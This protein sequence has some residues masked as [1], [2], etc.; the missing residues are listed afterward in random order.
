MTQYKFVTKWRAFTANAC[1]GVLRLFDPL[2]GALHLWYQ[3]I[4]SDLFGPFGYRTWILV[5]TTTVG[6]YSGVYA[7]IVARHD[8]LINRAL[9][10]RN[11]FVTMVS[12][13]NRTSFVTAM[14]DFGP[15]QTVPALRAPSPLEP[16]RWLET[17]RPNMGQLHRWAA[18]RLSACVA[19]ECGTDDGEYRID[20]L[21]ANLQGAK[22]KDTS[23]YSSRLLG[24]TLNHA[25]LRGTVLLGSNLRDADL[26]VADLR[27]AELGRVS[28]NG[29]DLRWS[30]LRGADM[31]GATL[32]DADRTVEFDGVQ[33][34]LEG[35]GAKLQGADLRE[36]EN[37]TCSQLQVAYWDAST[38]WPSGYVPPCRVNLPMKPCLQE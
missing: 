22:L 5:L 2:H 32:R 15:V 38:Q 24:A 37:W 27:G 3:N 17:N 8:R 34:G 35:E 16:L 26:R 28:L 13:G 36:I 25:D 20:L 7:V 14:K 4:W 29:A 18:Y 9:F 31:S 6:A 11:A 19:E 1:S 12:S 33:V 10:E 21:N 23:L 30:D